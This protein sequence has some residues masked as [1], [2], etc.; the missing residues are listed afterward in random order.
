MNVRRPI[1]ITRPS[2]TT[3]GM[4]NGR[5]DSKVEWTPAKEVFDP[6]QRRST[7]VHVAHTFVVYCKAHM[8]QLRMSRRK[9]ES[10]GCHSYLISFWPA[11]L[12]YISTSL[13]ALRQAK[14]DSA[15][16]TLHCSTRQKPRR[17]R[18]QCGHHIQHAY[19]LQ[20]LAK[21][22]SQPIQSATFLNRRNRYPCP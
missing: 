21:V 10:E 11:M 4:L 7:T 5:S 15:I 17:L 19:H 20:R 9:R 18:K 8:N 14:I 12:I 13:I 22:H 2:V 1:R 6:L 16:T 3:S